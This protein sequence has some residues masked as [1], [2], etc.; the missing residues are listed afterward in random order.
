MKEKGIRDGNLICLNLSRDLIPRN[1]GMI[2]ACKCAINNN[3][4]KAN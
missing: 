2:N 1:I 3:D 4:L